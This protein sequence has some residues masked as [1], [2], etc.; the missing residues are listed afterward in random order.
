MANNL[1]NYV[2]MM[3]TVQE[4]ANEGG[5]K[6]SPAEMQPIKMS[7]YEINFGRFARKGGGRRM[8]NNQ[9]LNSMDIKI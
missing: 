4:S 6:M 8:R 5:K 9:A 2:K 3:K 1:D 7:N